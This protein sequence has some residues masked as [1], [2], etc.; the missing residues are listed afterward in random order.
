M[1]ALHIGELLCNSCYMSFFL[2]RPPSGSGLPAPGASLQ[3]NLQKELLMRIYS[4]ENS[5]EPGNIGYNVV[6]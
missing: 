6:A 5:E 2:L 1:N 3:E 4:T